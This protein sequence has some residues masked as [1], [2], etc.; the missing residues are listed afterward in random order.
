MSHFGRQLFN[1]IIGL[2][3]Y[4][5][6]L[7]MTPFAP[8]WAE[9]GFLGLEVQGINAKL[10]KVLEKGNAAGVLVK[11]VAAGEA[12]AEAGFR[13]GDLII[14]FSRSRVSSFDDLL[15]AVVKTK[16]HQ[17]IAVKILR[18]GKAK[19][20][21][22]RLGKRPASWQVE[23]AEFR[24]YGKIGITVAAINNQVRERF[25]LPWGTIGLVVTLVDQNNKIVATGLSS[26]DVIVQANLKD[27]WRPQHLT[28]AINEAR[29]LGKS[30]ILILIQSASGFRYSLLP[31]AE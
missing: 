4:L 13:R 12:G 3:L 23:K 17:E 7:F 9:A 6:V 29:S 1:K 14:R 25:S 26:G 2:G 20:L 19:T 15:K 31:V 30:A 5:S 8:A 10:A 11:D 16:P 27:V 22:L 28:R 18:N 24:N 21:T